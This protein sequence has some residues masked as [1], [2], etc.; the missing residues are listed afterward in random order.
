MAC[1]RF[2][3]FCLVHAVIEAIMKKVTTYLK[4]V[5]YVNHLGLTVN[6]NHKQD[7]QRF[8]E[9]NANKKNYYSQFT[10]NQK[11]RK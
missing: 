8:I 6:I 1:Y 3:W 10:P 7:A 2:A 9:K 4:P 11:A 5:T